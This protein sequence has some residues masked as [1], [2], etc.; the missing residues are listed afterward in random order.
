MA[1]RPQEADVV[2]RRAED[3]SDDSGAMLARATAAHFVR[4]YGG[5]RTAGLVDQ[6]WLRRTALPLEEER[7]DPRRLAL[8]W[9]VLAYSANFRM[10]NNEYVE[11]ADR[12]LHYS[13]LAGDSPSDT[14]GPDLALILG[15]RPADE[16][17]RALEAIGQG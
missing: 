9:R 14:A 1:A 5:G 11:A 15:S 10:Q 7:G 17:L 13:R 12:E 6:E 2:A 16:A 8:L 4:V 3:A